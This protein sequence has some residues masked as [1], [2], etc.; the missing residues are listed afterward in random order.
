MNPIRKSLAGMPA[1][2]KRS[3]QE[4][5]YPKLLPEGET[6]PEW[7]LQSFDDSWHRHGRHWS[8][9]VFYVQ[10]GGAD[11]ATQLKEFQEHLADFSRLNVKVFGISS[12]E[13]ASHKQFAE[14]NGILFPLLTDR[15]GSV[16][17]QFHACMVIP[18]A[19]PM[20]I[21]TVYLVN[22]ERKIRLG[23]RGKPSVAAIVRSITALQQATKTGM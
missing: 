8:I 14:E 5:V 16:A 23:N 9:L 4:R 19:G 22:P 10:D 12:E 11:D 21:R 20:Q 13:S 15:G 17:R 6:A 7:H 18:I 3:I 1:P 2:L